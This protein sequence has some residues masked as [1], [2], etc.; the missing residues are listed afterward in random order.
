MELLPQYSAYAIPTD[1]IYYDADFNCRAEFTLQ[2]VRDLADSITAEGLHFPLVVQ[3]WTEQPGFEFRLIAGHRRFRSIITFLNW[4]TIPATIRTGLT[5]HQAR[6]LNVTENLERKDLNIW[7]EARALERLYPNGVSLRDAAKELKKTTTWVFVRQHLL[8]MPPEVQQKAAAGLLS[9][10]NLYALAGVSRE[11]QVMA[12]EQ[13][14]NARTLG[15]GK[16]LP[17]V[18][19]AYKRRNSRVRSKEE[20]NHMIERMLTAG[21]GGLPPRVGAWCAGNISDEDLWRD[22]ESTLKTTCAG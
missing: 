16:R 15:K 11:K 3:P 21:I 8:R 10:A 18:E 4:P 13:I 12:A 19:S 17:G 14:A 2:S 7:E 22:V 9:Q 1:S 5:E 20:I 6:L